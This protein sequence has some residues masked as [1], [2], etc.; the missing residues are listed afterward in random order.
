MMDEKMIGS[1]EDVK[2]S[3]QF[4]TFVFPSPRNFSIRLWDQHELT[5]DLNPAFTLVLNHP[6]ALRRMFTIPIEL[7]M[8]EAYI[9]DDFDIEGDWFAAFDLV[10]QLA[11]RNL[12]A[13]DTAKLVRAVQLLPKSDKER[14]VTR[15]PARLKGKVHSKK[16]DQEAIQYH[17]NVGNQFYTLWLDKNM[18]YSTAYFPDGGED[19]ETAQVKKM[20]HICRKLRLKPGEKLLDIGCGWGG[21]ARH[22]AQEYGVQVLGVTLSDQQAE[23]ASQRIEQLDL[24]DQVQIAMQDYRDL[25]QNSFD[26]IVSVGM[27]EHV[28]R[29][30]LPEYFSHVYRLLRPG[31]LFLNHG[32][33]RLAV[34][35]DLKDVK[36]GNR[37]FKHSSRVAS[38]FEEKVLGA[39][40]FTQKYIFPDGELV[41]VSEANL[42]AD[43][44]GFEVRDVENLREHYAL[45]LRAWV[46][47][48]EEKHQEAAALV[49]ES[50]YR[51]WRLYMSHSALQFESGKISV[52]QS[53]LAKP[54][55]GKVDLPMSR[56]DLY[57]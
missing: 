40:S 2:N 49:G 53:L 32:I 38:Y 13:S 15:S 20:E 47:R 52:N 31:G 27:F 11:K 37:V 26:K 17:Y 24:K 14:A 55:D 6:G 54:A 51:T 23:F 25:D 16:R 3:I 4:L 50:V 57:R 41:S 30:H 39:N 21:L 29:S 10:N 35:D 9:Y 48:L 46:R 7:G 42:V 34:P 22:A 43:A 45:T 8:G 44:A 18:Q 33:S 5:G 12:S 28:G 1:E 19:L 36:G 56:A